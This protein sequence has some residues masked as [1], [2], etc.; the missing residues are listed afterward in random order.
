[1]AKTSAERQAA[2]RTRHLKDG[3]GERLNVVVSLS[4]AMALRRLAAHGGTSQRHVL[5]TLLAEAQTKATSR[6]S[7]DQ[8]TAYYD[9]VSID[10]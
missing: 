3:E 1:M 10:Q 7:A 6:M 4:A 9:A 8:Q 5:E 2:Y